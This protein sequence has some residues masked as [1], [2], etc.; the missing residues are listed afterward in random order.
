[1]TYARWVNGS[2]DETAIVTVSYNSSDQLEKFLNS[3][4]A[5]TRQ[6]SR[7]VVV[8][9]A[10]QDT[11]QSIR[12]ASSHGAEVL[13]LSENLGYGGAIN[14]AIS[15]LPPS[16]GTILICNPDLEISPDTVETLYE[17]LA[18]DSGVGSVGPRILNTDGTIYRSARSIPS[19]GI[20]VGHALFAR[21]WPTNPW[22]SAY[23]EA[24]TSGVRDAGWLSGACLMVNR[25]AF[26]SIG[27]FDDHFFMYFEDVD[28]GYRLAKAGFRN[29]Y[30]P[31]TSVVHVGGL[32]TK[33]VS[34][35]MLIAHHN[36]AYRFLSKKYS[37]PWW[38]P[39][40][41]ALRVSLLLRAR[42]LTRKKFR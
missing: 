11:D 4:Q 40:R 16:V 12:I 39:L 28:L 23:H 8:D 21:A 26:E 3:L 2:N 27:G 36:S 1:M 29:R 20:G 13:T 25:V 24:N 32:S 18:S 10:S 34:A 14:R 17:V 37:E 38:A 5:S 35:Q 19:L 9:N 31:R 41:G 7:V 15:T 42:L 22:T 30:E 6:C 33:S